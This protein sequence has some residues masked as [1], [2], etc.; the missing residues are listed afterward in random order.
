MVRRMA[1]IP[2]CACRIGAKSML[3]KELPI[4]LNEYTTRM[5]CIIILLGAATIHF[6]GWYT[7]GGVFVVYG[8]LTLWLAHLIAKAPICVEPTGTADRADW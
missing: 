2:E 4:A 5:A 8:I 3:D 7:L 1:L 6:L